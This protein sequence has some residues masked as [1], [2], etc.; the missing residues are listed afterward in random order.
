MRTLSN[1]KDLSNDIAPNINNGRTLPRRI[2][3]RQ[4]RR[5]NAN[6]AVHLRNIYDAS[7]INQDTLNRLSNIPIQRTNVHY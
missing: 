5:Q 4:I 2:R 3:S 6:R 7:F 1:Q